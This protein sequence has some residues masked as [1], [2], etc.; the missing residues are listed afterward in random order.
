MADPYLFLQDLMVIFL[1]AYVAGAVCRRLNLSPIVGY[2]TAGLIIG[3]PEIA[4]P[5]VTD[6]ERISILA[7]LGVVFLMFSI[8]LQFGLQKVKKVGAKVIFSTLLIALLVLSATRI[9][10][11]LIGLSTAAGIAL[12]AVFMNSSSAIISKTLEETGVTHERKGQL[13][14]STT[15]LEDIVAVVMLAVLGSYLTIEGTTSSQ[16]PLT[17]ILTVGGFA[18]LLFILGTLVVPR[19]LL[20]NSTS[21]SSESRTILV[22]G[23]VFLFAVLAVQAGYSVA[24]GAFLCGMI[25]AGSRE[26][27]N[28]EKS[29][30]GLKDLFL[31]LFFVTIGMMIDIRSI[32]DAMG[33]IALG[34]T[35]AIAGRTLAAFIA[36]VIIG[37]NP[38]SAFQTALCITPIGEFSF[39]IAGVAVAGGLLGETFQAAVVG[40]V[41]GT[42]LLSPLLIA[43]NVRLSAFIP[44]KWDHQAGR[45]RKAYAE[46]WAKS[47]TGSHRTKVWP[48]LRRRVWQ[49]G[50][51]LIFVSGLLVF[52]NLIYKRFYEFLPGMMDERI[53][54]TI[55]W[56]LLTVVVMIPLF[57]IWR[58]ISAVCMILAEN[59]S[60]GRTLEPNKT[61]SISRLFKILAGLLLFIWLWNVFPADLSMLQS[62]LVFLALG[63]VLLLVGRHKLNRFHS[64]MEC[65]F[66]DSLEDTQSTDIKKAFREWDKADWNLNLSEILV[67]EQTSWAGLPLERV[68]LRE[69]T[70]CSVVGLQRHGFTLS[71]VGPNTHLFPGDQLLLIGDEHQIAKA[72]E[73]LRTPENGEDETNANPLEN[74]ILRAFTIAENST[75]IGRTLAELQWPTIYRIQVVALKRDGETSTKI[76][77]HT[78]L[79][80]LDSLLLLGAENNLNAFSDS[81]TPPPSS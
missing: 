56:V 22:G 58:N 47:N 5:Y 15:L 17:T 80:P 8:G 2:I 62:L 79:Q 70:G 44:Q 27:H 51:E 78:R 37:E 38:R 74:Q 13:A 10:A 6:E 26:R 34:I 11:D 28:I 76:N 23:A 64:E 72:E 4:F 19:L 35:G 41:L 42:S 71:H 9:S 61:R 33:W 14:L 3:T 54:S 32:P 1:S 25:L 49:I 46:L 30:Q 52:S 39:I 75:F 59:F 67:P 81:P 69:R 55:F 24:L 31:T 50:I 18:V 73:L 60:A 65:L 43:H 53:Y 20:R 57:A 77:A 68:H 16:S 12:A 40:T 45:I 63:V 36:F 48:L 66:E 7:Q 21:K 29:F